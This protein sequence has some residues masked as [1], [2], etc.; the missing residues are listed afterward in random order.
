MHP[1]LVMATVVSVVTLPVIVLGLIDPL[2][3]GLAVLVAGALILAT[4]L[5]A[6]VPVP[7]LEW[8]AWVTAIVTGGLAILGAATNYPRPLPAWVWV[9]VVAYEIAV[10]LTLVG[11]GIHVARHLRQMRA[12]RHPARSVRAAP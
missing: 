4:W 1:S 3:G 9:L 2:E 7:V 5:I 12:R 8:T 11:A 6:R 10:V